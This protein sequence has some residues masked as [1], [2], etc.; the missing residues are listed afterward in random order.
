METIQKLLDSLWNF[1][2]SLPICHHLPERSGLWG[3]DFPL[4]CRCTGLYSFLIF[5]FIGN[6]FLN[7]GYTG[8]R[9]TLIVLI[10]LSVLTGIEAVLEIVFG[11]DL[12]NLTRLVTGAV[13]G[14]AIGFLLS[15]GLFGK[16]EYYYN[17]LEELIEFKRNVLHSNNLI[18]QRFFNK[19]WFVTVRKRH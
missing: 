17:L 14:C 2:Y 5:G 7:I 8:R 10:G 6:V 19:E 3:L 13:S 16:S 1:I 11:I 18:L 9:R 4:C 15:I 12:G